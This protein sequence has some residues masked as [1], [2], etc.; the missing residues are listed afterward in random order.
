MEQF[1]GYLIPGL[2]LGTVYT[3]ISLG[4]ITIYRTTQVLNMA[5][6]EFF[7]LG[8]Y[9]VFMMVSQL[10]LP[11]WLGLFLAFALMALLGAV[12]ERFTLRPMVGQP[13]FAIIL[14]TLGLSVVLRG[15]IVLV[16][17][18]TILP[19]PS[20]FATGGVEFLGV[21][22]PTQYVW[23][24]GISLVIA[25]ALVYFFNRTK[26]GL[27][28]TAAA[29]DIQVA[30]SCGVSVNKITAAAWMIA[31]VITGV[32]GFLLCSITGVYPEMGALGLRS[33]AVVLAAGMESL[34]GAMIMGPVVGAIEMLAAGYLDPYVGGG[35]R[36]IIAFA[37]LI[38]FLLFRPQGLFGWKII[39]RV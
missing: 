14:M 15:V 7:L 34:A 31:A 20:L 25:G 39:E 1:L 23:F 9:A 35:I 13:V 21:T 2:M 29:D 17:S 5:Q 12:T 24:T 36:D 4:F 38:I 16:W 26:I 8:A 11:I 6:G 30:Q 10:N 27:M 32:G 19:M 22:V 28:M 3:V 37:V 18:D 33:L